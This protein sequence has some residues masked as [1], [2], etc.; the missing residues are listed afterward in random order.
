MCGW[1]LTSSAAV[2]ATRARAPS[3]GA[4]DGQPMATRLSMPLASCENN[5]P[6]LVTSRTAP[7]NTQ[8]AERNRRDA[9]QAGRV[10]RARQRCKV[11]PLD[12]DGTLIVSVYIEIDAPM[13]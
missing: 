6:L 9:R 7:I 3:P 1:L 11:T 12:V 10:P 5:E 13:H 8:W 4:D 2:L